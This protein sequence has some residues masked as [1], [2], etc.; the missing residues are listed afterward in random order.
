M[1]REK[2]ITSVS[3]IEELAKAVRSGNG[4]IPI[5]K[6]TGGDARIPDPCFGSLVIDR[7]DFELRVRSYPLPNQVGVMES[8]ILDK[9]LGHSVLELLCTLDGH[10]NVVIKN[11]IGNK[12]NRSMTRGI[13]GHYQF[14]SV[15]AG[16]GQLSA[17]GAS[18][19][20]MVSRIAA[21]E[22]R[23]KNLKQTT[24][25]ECSLE[26]EV[27]S[28]WGIHSF[29]GDIRPYRYK[30]RQEGDDL[31]INV[32]L[33]QEEISP[34]ADLDSKFMDALTLS[35]NWINGGHPYTY[36][37]SHERDHKLVQSAVMPIRGA[38]RCRPCLAS[39]TFGAPKAAE[40]MESSI[41]FFSAETPLSKD[42]ELFLW[43]YR[44]ATAEGPI[45]LSMLLQSCSLLEGVVGLTLRHSMGLDKKSID[46]LRMPGGAAEPRRKSSAKERLY[47]AGFYLG[48]DWDKQ[49]IGVFDTWKKV[50]DA[51]A[52]GNLAEFQQHN[53]NTTLE[54]YGQVVQAFNAITLRLVGYQGEIQMNDKW[55]AIPG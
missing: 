26:G 21:S 2:L 31:V 20:S 41:R 32:Y 14:D 13:T 11:V 19:I 54:S 49:L 45:T 36:F 46:A 16:D 6:L 24:I 35:L 23:L 8:M 9:Q 17:G 51:L 52:H 42:L 15:A 30:I 18:S 40:V 44:D 28:S 29:G 43:Q 39:T 34:S 37:R 4:C 10:L 50:R 5:T 38:P 22:L 27:E 12:S 3:S 47:H 55:Y 25:T 53:P 48:F 1:D 33:I 7:D